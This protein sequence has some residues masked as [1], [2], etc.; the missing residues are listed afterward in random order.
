MLV[1]DT[2]KKDDCGAILTE[3]APPAALFGGWAAL[4]LMPLSQPGIMLTCHQA[5][6]YRLTFIYICLD[7][8]AALRQGHVSHRTKPGNVQNPKTERALAK[9]T[10]RSVNAK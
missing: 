1:A 7:D 5:L 6:G 10:N 4:L 2:A 9:S 3:D 8:P